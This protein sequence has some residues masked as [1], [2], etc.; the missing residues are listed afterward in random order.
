MILTFFVLLT[1]IALNAVHAY[2]ANLA[3]PRPISPSAFLTAFDSSIYCNDSQTAQEIIPN[4]C[5]AA[6]IQLPIDRPGDVYYLA[7]HNQYFYPEFSKFPTEERHRLPKGA[8]LGTCAVEVRLAENGVHDT[9][10]WRIIRLRL[11]N[12]VDRCGEGMG[13]G[14]LTVTGVMKDIEVK[15]YATPVS[16]RSDGLV[17]GNGSLATGR[18]NSLSGVS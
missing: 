17:M 14:G 11:N 18:L 6:M 16:P 7:E 13:I 9:T 3:L 15:V 4:H 5:R 10:S 1:A 12:V 2:P 8:E